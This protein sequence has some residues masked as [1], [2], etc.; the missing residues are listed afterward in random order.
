MVALVPAE[1]FTTGSN[2]NDSPDRIND[3]LPAASLVVQGTQRSRTNKGHAKR[4]TA[5]VQIWTRKHADG[6]ALT[7]AMN[8]AFENVDWST[9]IGQ[10]TVNVLSSRIENEYSLEEDDGAWQFVFDLELFYAVTATP[11]PE[12]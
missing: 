11:A 5:R 8:A 1:R 4:A 10:K 6:I 7:E 3:Q 2:V 9:S 12:E